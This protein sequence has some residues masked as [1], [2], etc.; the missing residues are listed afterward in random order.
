MPG[1][2]EPLESASSATAAR[3]DAVPITDN[4]TALGTREGA[5]NLAN[6]FSAPSKA[7]PSS[8]IR[9]GTD[10]SAHSWSCPGAAS[11]VSQCGP[12]GLGQLWHPPQLSSHGVDDLMLIRSGEQTGSGQCS[13]HPRK[14]PAGQRVGA[15]STEGGPHGEGR[16]WKRSPL[17]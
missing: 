14:M 16:G 11:A 17:R 12:Q 8:Y 6:V 9:H 3:L 2:R 13:R 7:D 1:A 15:K 4:A 10:S 5:L